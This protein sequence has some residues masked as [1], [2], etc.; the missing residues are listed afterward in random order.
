MISGLIYIAAAALIGFIGRNH[1]FTFWGW[2]AI[3]VIFTPLLASLMLW[4]AL[5]ISS[6]EEK[7]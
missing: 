5:G 3:S 4:I 7:V 6:G 1:K 2:A